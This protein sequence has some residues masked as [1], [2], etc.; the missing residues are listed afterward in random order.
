MTASVTDIRTR[1]PDAS[2]RADRLASSPL[3]PAI[4]S[5]YAA[6]GVTPADLDPE[7]ALFA[8]LRAA[9]EAMTP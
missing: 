9:L 2:S 8:P 6:A 1:K 4:A 3:L 7:V 5:A